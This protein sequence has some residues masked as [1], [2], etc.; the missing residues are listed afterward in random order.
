MVDTR[1]TEDIVTDRALDQFPIQKFQQDLLYWFE[2][3]MRDLPWRQDKDP[4]KVWV[5]EIMLQQT[6]VDTVIPYYE[7]FMSAFPTLES[8]ANA[9]EKDVLKQWEGLGYYSRARNLQTAVREVKE[10]YGGQV[11]DDPKEIAKLKGVGPYTAGAI[12]SIAY[13]KK[14]PAVDGNVMR[15]LSRILAIEDDIAKVRTRKRF[16]SIVRQLIPE[17]HAS[18]F[19]QGMMELGALVCTPKSPQC[20]TCPVRAHCRAQEQGIEHTLPVKAKKKKPKRVTLVAALVTSG[21][22]V[23]IRQRPQEGL[24]ARLFE[25]PN[26]ERTSESAEEDISKY[27]FEQYGL[28]CLTQKKGHSVQHTFTHLIWDIDVYH[29]VLTH[30]Q[31]AEHPLPEGTLWA[32]LSDLDTYAFPVSHQKMR[33]QLNI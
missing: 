19:N 20:L 16:E 14:E 13:D 33:N 31:L 6:Q 22:K 8:L 1:K 26:T 2:R 27:L 15:V 23:L 4:Y 12:L 25:F 5:S 32:P 17:G 24:L 29:L 10:T 28:T 21:D 18:Y 30:D 9:E 7:N 3:N 11:P